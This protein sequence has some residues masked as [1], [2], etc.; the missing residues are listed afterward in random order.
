M[1]QTS[2]SR[3]QALQ[4][5]AAG[6][7]FALSR[8]AAYA[9]GTA[10]P[11]A[12]PISGEDVPELL[13]FDTAMHDVMAAWGLPGGQLA[14][15]K[16]DRLIYSRGFGFASVEDQE[17]VGTD[18]LFRIASN[19]KPITAVA[20]LMLVDAGE[21]ALD[22]PVFPLLAYES[23]PNA[24][25]DSRLDSIT[26][27]QLLVH[28]GG[29]NSSA[30]YDPQYLPW[31]LYASHLFN[32]ESPAEAET[33]IR[34]MLTQP[35]D[36]DPGTQS[37]YSNFGFNVLGRVIEHVSG[38][39]YEQ[40]VVDNM[41]TPSEITT[42]AIGGTTLGERMPGEVRY[43]SPEGLEQFPSV[44][45][46]DGFVPAGYGSY[47]MRSLDAH[48][49][50]IASAQDLVRFVLAVDGTKGDALLTPEMVSAMETTARPPSAAAGAG[51]VEESLGLGW[52]S[53]PQD[54][55][56]EWSHAGALVGSN[57][58]WVVRKPDGITLAYMFNSL[59]ENYGGFFNQ[60]NP[61]LQDLIE[62]TSE[63]PDVDLFT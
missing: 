6:T 3:R 44:F 22:T 56:Y 59:P 55:G 51:N 50:W 23:L 30:G 1:H 41:L 39:T 9:Q 13:A 24:P 57:S 53:V 4:I 48:G 61:R 18:S 35:L 54:D 10:T 42:M 8:R 62:S 19:S 16:N 47:Y 29:W 31:P 26:V 63:W 2:L 7:A 46:D 43:Y 21:I 11:A 34:F 36:F 33:I 25:Y 49:G 17:V 28:S 32:T 12:L 27:E 60:I 58:A 45:P 15:A 20:V 38:G 52:N 40:F 5:G 37:A 14:I